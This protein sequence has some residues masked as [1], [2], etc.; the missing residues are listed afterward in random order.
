MNL[1]TKKPPVSVGT[2]DDV[3][4]WMAGVMPAVNPIVS[5]LDQIIRKSLKD[6]RFA[7]KWGKAYYGSAQLGWCI[8]LAAYHVSVNV[9]FLNGDRLHEP[10]SLGDATRYVKIKSREELKSAQILAWI[11]ESCGMPG[12][13][14]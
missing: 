6:P 2:H 8:E 13:T 1:N 3:D 4:R 5:E 14:G 9:V 10:P 11:K 12:W 7:I